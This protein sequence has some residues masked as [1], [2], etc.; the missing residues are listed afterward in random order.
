MNQGQENVQKSFYDLNMTIQSLTNSINSSE[1]ESRHLKNQEKEM[2]GAQ[3][4]I[5]QRSRI[6]SAMQEAQQSGKLSGICGRLGDLGSIDAKYD[7]AV[8]SACNQLDWIVVETIYDA[9]KAV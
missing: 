2:S 7:V 4:D 8:S 5:R 6:L 1:Q 3:N 9:E